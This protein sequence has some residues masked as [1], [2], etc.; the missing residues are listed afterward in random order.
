MLYG[1]L[2]QSVKGRR[3][4]AAPASTMGS[5]SS[6]AQSTRIAS[7]CT[8]CTD[9]RSAV[10]SSRAAHEA[11]VDLE[12]PHLGAGC[13]ERDGERTEPCADLDHAIPG[14]DSGIPH[15]RSREVGVDQEVLAERLRRADAVASGELADRD[16]AERRRAALTRRC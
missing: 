12:S 6:A 3:A 13:S 8:T 4:A 10:T 16:R 15:D 2:A 1:R 5:P 9:A 14:A 11:A 7:A